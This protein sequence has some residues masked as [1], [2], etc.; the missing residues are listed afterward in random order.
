MVRGACLECGEPID[1]DEIDE[2]C[3]HCGNQVRFSGPSLGRHTEMLGERLRQAESEKDRDLISA[4]LHFVGCGILERADLFRFERGFMSENIKENLL[5]AVESSREI[6]GGPLLVCP[7][8]DEQMNVWTKS[9]IGEEYTRK[10]NFD[11]E[12]TLA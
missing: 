5:I 7:V 12:G 8:C 10:M 9:I 4:F 2:N 1:W 3:L 6:E 11:D